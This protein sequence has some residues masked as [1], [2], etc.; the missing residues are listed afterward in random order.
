MKKQNLGI[1]LC[2]PMEI[3]LLHCSRG[4]HQKSPN[5]GITIQDYQNSSDSGIELPIDSGINKSQDA[6]YNYNNNDHGVMEI[7]NNG[8]DDN[9]NGEV[10]EGCFCSTTNK[11]KQNCYP[12]DPNTIGVGICKMGEQECVNYGEM[13]MWDDCIG[14]ITPEDEVC[15]GLD[16]DCNGGVD[17]GLTRECSNNCGS[18]I[19]T[20]VN[21]AYINCTA[22]VF[23]RS[24]CTECG[25]N[26]VQSNHG[27][28]CD[29]TDGCRSDCTKC[30]DGII[31]S[32]HDEMCDGGSLC[33]SSC[34]KKNPRTCEASPPF[35]ADFFSDWPKLML[36]HPTAPPF[37]EE[38]F[39]VEDPYNNV[40]FTLRAAADS[41]WDQMHEEALFTLNGPDGKITLGQTIDCD[42]HKPHDDLHTECASIEKCLMLSAG[43][44]TL[45]VEP[46]NQGHSVMVLTNTVN[47]CVP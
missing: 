38:T 13:A 35:T 41:G 19:E 28:T 26:V 46:I 29:G 4:I 30:G 14:A 23:S 45:R 44:Y 3:F 36:N 15:D 39:E 34:Q 20:C 37:A 22:P 24:D 33:D 25:D 32:E 6:N 5:E 43:R 9:S 47:Q 10:D 31:Q 7:C 8:L 18:G 40:C 17:D 27:E 12:G 42:N 11:M 1:Y 2:I 16:N 21:G